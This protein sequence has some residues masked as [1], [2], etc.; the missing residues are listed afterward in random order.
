MEAAGGW[1]NR[2]GPGLVAAGQGAD[3]NFC[4][5]G[6]GPSPSVMWGSYSL[7][8]PCLM[9]RPSPRQA[10]LCGWVSFRACGSE[11][12]L[13]LRPHVAPGSVWLRANAS[14]SAQSW[15]MRGPPQAPRGWEDQGRWGEARPSAKLHSQGRKQTLCPPR[16][17]KASCWAGRFPL[18]RTC[19]ALEVACALWA[20]AGSEARAAICQLAESFP[21]RVPSLGT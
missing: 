17:M 14:G 11:P 4:P 18:G 1:G 21:G 7:G 13:G 9:P 5:G 15:E 8:S 16:L 19:P 20:L 2:A 3:G 6:G 12:G 10:W